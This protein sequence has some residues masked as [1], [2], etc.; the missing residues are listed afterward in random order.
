MEK[1]GKIFDSE[2]MSHPSIWKTSGEILKMMAL[3]QAR[4]TSA[5]GLALGTSVRGDREPG[6]LV[7]G[8]LPS[9]FCRFWLGIHICIKGP[10]KPK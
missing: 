10:I 4:R 8:D 6:F 3:D 1:V 2:Q 7:L 9:V 5:V